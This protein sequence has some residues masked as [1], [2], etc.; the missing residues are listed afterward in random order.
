MIVTQPEKIIF[1]T[2][3]CGY[4]GK[5]L[6]GYARIEGHKSCIKKGREMNALKMAKEGFIDSRQIDEREQF[7]KSHPD[8]FIGPDG[9]T[10]NQRLAK[11]ETQR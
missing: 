11:Q 5:P 2:E 10:Y 8:T 1:E 3:T 7:L 6:V 9:L 4:C